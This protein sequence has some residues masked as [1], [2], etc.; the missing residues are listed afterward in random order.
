MSD[1]KKYI[2]KR[3][4]RDPEF[5]EDFNSGYEQFKIGVMLKHGTRHEYPISNKE[6]PTDEGNKKQQPR[7]RA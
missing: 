2:N 5:A 7:H 6:Y 1:L 3:K 4:A